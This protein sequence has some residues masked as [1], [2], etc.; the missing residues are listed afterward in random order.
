MNAMPRSANGKRSE[1]QCRRA[2]IRYA[3]GSVAHL[4]PGISLANDLIAD[5]RRGEA[6]PTPERKEAARRA[7]SRD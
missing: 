5:R 2:A 3:E 4:A 6:R 1:R 7:T